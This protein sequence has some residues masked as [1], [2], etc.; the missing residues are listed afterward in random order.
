MEQA[1]GQCHGGGSPDPAAFYHG[2]SCVFWMGNLLQTRLIVY[3]AMQDTA[4]C[5]AEYQY[6]YSYV[7]DEKQWIYRETVSMF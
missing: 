2:S 6:A 1:G 4:Q 5:L 3:D 7:Q